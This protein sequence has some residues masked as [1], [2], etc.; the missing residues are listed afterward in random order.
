MPIDNIYNMGNFLLNHFE[1]SVLNKGLSFVIT[2]N[3]VTKD[4]V[5]K[6]FLKFKRRILLHYHFFTRPT[7]KIRTLP[8]KFRSGSNWEPPNY[9]QK[10]LNSFFK[11]VSKDL[12][13]LYEQPKHNNTNLSP[14]EITALKNLEGRKEMVIKPA[15]KGV[16]LYCGPPNYT[17]RRQTGNWEITTTIRSKLRTKYLPYQWR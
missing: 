8:N 6:A 4:E 12:L 13:E 17:L 16:R 10:T 14:A 5:F 1:Q 11:N 3:M 7:N 9:K 2:P 15:D